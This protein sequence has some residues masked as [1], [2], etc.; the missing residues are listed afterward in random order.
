[1]MSTRRAISLMRVVASRSS[2]S[3]GGTLSGSLSHSYRYI[4]DF[5]TPA[6]MHSTGEST[7]NYSIGPVMHGVNA[8]AEATG[9]PWWA[10]IG[11]FGLGVR[12]AMLPVTLKAARASA[13][14]VS[15]WRKINSPEIRVSADSFAEFLRKY[16]TH[17]KQSNIPHPAWIVA[18]PALQ[19][20]VFISAMSAVRTM[21]LIPYP[22]ELKTGG[23]GWFPDLTASAVHFGHVFE[24]PMGPY[25][26]ILPVTIALTMYANIA[27]AFPDRPINQQNNQQSNQVAVW[28]LS[29]IRLALEWAVVPLFITALQLPHG[30]LCYWV[31]SSAYG[32]AQQHVMK[33]ANRG[34]V[35]KRHDTPSSSDKTIDA[36]FLH[37]AELRAN[38]DFVGAASVLKSILAKQPEN[39]RAHFALGQT[40]SGCS[41]WEEAAEA[42]L[43]AAQLEGNAVQKGRAWFGAGVALHQSK[44]VLDSFG[45]NTRMSALDAF[46]K[47]ATGQSDP[48]TRVRALIAAAAIEEKAGRLDEAVRLF[49]LAAKLE[50]KVQDLYLKPLEERMKGDRPCTR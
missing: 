33:A 3:P 31:T 29:K 42:Y 34:G 2:T 12:T 47:A 41:Q 15:I 49:R 37:A 35:R 36:L 24:A 23:I 22:P 20:P 19:L 1:M 4:S 8:L 26:A 13:G 5:G 40:L 28:L 27:T 46:L 21:C 30:A 50:P 44:N 16:H 10:T 11:L 14:A 17:R 38:R 9:L 18:S 6:E 32:L 45:K 7:A 48:S 43:S 39:A 25:G